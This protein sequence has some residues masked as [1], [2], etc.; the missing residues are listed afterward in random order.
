MNKQTPG[1]GFAKALLRASSL[2]MLAFLNLKVCNVGQYHPMIPGSDLQQP[3]AHQK[4][5][6]IPRPRAYHDLCN[7]ESG[8]LTLPG[9][10]PNTV[11]A[12][13]VDVS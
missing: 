7:L 10:T 4:D 9:T 8:M 2:A 6:S 11:D 5:I 1:E 3:S 12:N 13:T